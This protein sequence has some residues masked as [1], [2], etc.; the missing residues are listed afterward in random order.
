MMADLRSVEKARLRMSTTAASRGTVPLARRA[1]S[2][3]VGSRPAGRLSATNQSRSSSDLAAVLRPAPD[4][5]VMMTISC[6][7]PS[8]FMLSPPIVVRAGASPAAPSPPRGPAAAPVPR[9][10]RA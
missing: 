5:P 2:A 9:M 3:I 1:S 10:Q 4:R 8:P 7:A 6:A